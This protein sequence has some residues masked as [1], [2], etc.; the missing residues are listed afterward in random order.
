MGNVRWGWGQRFLVAVY[1]AAIAGWLALEAGAPPGAIALTAILIWIA[2]V[3]IMAVPERFSYHVDAF[4]RNAVASWRDRLWLAVIVAA[5]VGFSV[6]FGQFDARVHLGAIV[7]ASIATGVGAVA[8]LVAGERYWREMA[9]ITP[10][11]TVKILVVLAAGSIP[12]S[13]AFD[14]PAPAVIVTA[15]GGLLAIQMMW[16]RR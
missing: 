4:G 2:A 3:A 11:T 5:L 12:L 8:L 15:W 9:E 1:Y 7:V 13:I 6:S 14:S 10:G 16:F